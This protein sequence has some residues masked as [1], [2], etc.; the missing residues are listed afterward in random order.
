MIYP[1]LVH[2]RGIESQRVIFETQIYMNAIPRVGECIDLGKL[3]GIHQILQVIYTPS[4]YGDTKIKI[5]CL[6]GN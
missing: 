2:S 4:P 6:R 1:I 3:D 5:I